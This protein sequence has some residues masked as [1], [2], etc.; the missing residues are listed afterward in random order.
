MVRSESEKEERTEL[1]ELLYDRWSAILCIIHNVSPVTEWRRK[2]TK[3][4]RVR[5]AKASTRPQSTHGQSFS[6][7]YVHTHWQH[8]QPLVF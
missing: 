6:F 4:V 3:G 1:T 5:E 8:H 7:H 2:E